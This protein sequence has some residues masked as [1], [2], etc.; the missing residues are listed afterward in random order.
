VVLAEKGD[1]PV[2][3][4]SKPHLKA[5]GNVIRRSPPVSF[6]GMEITVLSVFHILRGSTPGTGT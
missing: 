6:S 3:K 1:I 2:P 5:G 4:V